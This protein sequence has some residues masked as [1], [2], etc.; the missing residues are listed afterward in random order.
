MTFC[1]W[2]PAPFAVLVAVLRHARQAGHAVAPLA[3]AAAVTRAL[4]GFGGGG[5]GRRGERAWWCR[6]EPQAGRS[7]QPLCTVPA[8]DGRSDSSRRAEELRTHRQA[9]IAAKAIRLVVPAAGA[10]VAQPADGRLLA[11][12]AIEE[13]GGAV[14]QIGGAAGAVGL[15]AVAFDAL[16]QVQ[17]GGGGKTQRA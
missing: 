10:G 15:Q 6:G 7:L 14:G 3:Q 5:A 17:G 12:A 11:G 13:G 9:Q 1:T 4:Q 16:R 2:R 8:F